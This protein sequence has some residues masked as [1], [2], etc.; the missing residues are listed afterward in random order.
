MSL[1]QSSSA[2][3]ASHNRI[4]QHQQTF[5]SR[6]VLRTLAFVCSNKVTE[7]VAMSKHA[8]VCL[9]QL[10]GYSKHSYLFLGSSM[11]QTLRNASITSLDRLELGAATTTR[12]GLSVHLGCGT[13][14]TAASL[15]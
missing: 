2:A 8:T 15:T 4:V 11:D 14:M 1:Q 10:P 7:S 12:S 6:Y 13:A 5:A 3:V 9:D